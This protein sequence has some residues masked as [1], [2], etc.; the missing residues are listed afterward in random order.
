MNVSRQRATDLVTAIILVG[1]LALTTPSRAPAQETAETPEATT[2]APSEAPQISGIYA[3]F[4]PYAGLSVYSNDV[5]LNEK[6]IYGA[7]LGVIFHPFFGIEGVYGWSPAETEHGPTLYTPAGDPPPGAAVGGDFHHFGLD[8]VF[9]PP[10]SSIIAP[11]VAAG[12]SRVSLKSDDTTVETTNRTGFEAAAGFKLRVAPRIAARLEARDVMFTFDSPPAP[13]D[14]LTHNFIFSAGLQLALGG[15]LG[16]SDADNDGVADNRDNCP[17]TALGVLVDA[18]GCPMDGDN[19]GVPDGIDQCANTPAGAQVDA[20][21][22]PLDADN[23][24]VPDGVD[25]CANTPAGASVDARGCPA[26]A[27]NDGV[28][29][30]VDQCANTPA[31]A[32]VD[33]RGCPTD[34]DADGIPDGADLCPNTPAG[35]QVDKDGCPIE[36]SEKEVELLDTGK[37]TVRDIHF[38]TAKW[39]ILP[40]SYAVLDEIGGV[41]IQWPQLRIEIG[42]HADARGSDEYNLDLSQKRAQAVLD[43]LLQHFPQIDRAQY[44]AVGYGERQPVASNKTVEGMAR[45]RRVE[46]KVLNT[47]VLTKERERRHL[48]KKDE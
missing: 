30:G 15:R 13:T 14:A 4:T 27:D 6:P 48:L 5:N 19:D 9:T 45:N 8:L 42:G 16:T 20:K 12:A 24:G 17:G 28:P 36:V 7:K 39:E 31:G 34:S 3:T 41:L 23:D 37:I 47:E 11:Y 18:R 1:G 25:Q 22:C 46:F 40:D 21:G 26:D 29:D 35:A 43:Y 10:V 33:A 38:E 44:T 2:A 32:S